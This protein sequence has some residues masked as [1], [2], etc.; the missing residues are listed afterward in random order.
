MWVQDRKQR[1]K[2]L[3]AGAVK[4][5]LRKLKG[6]NEADSIAAIEDAIERGWQS[7]FP[8][9]QGSK[10]TAPPAGV[11]IAGGFADDLAMFRAIGQ[12]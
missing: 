8:Q 3:T 11:V 7:F 9:K 6:F 5:Q 4:L 2:P 1:R 12:Q 10:F